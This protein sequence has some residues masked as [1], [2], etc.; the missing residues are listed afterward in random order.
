MIQDLIM[1]GVFIVFIPTFFPQIHDCQTGKSKMNLFS[2][3][4]TM[5]GLSIVSVCL[6]S[7]GA[8][9]SSVLEAVVAF[10]WL[11]CFYY[12]RRQI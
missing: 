7:L 9:F 11:L 3:G 4:V 8:I 1:S 6:F 2:C 12:S 10:E 5:I